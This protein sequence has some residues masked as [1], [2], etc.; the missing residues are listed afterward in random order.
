MGF[1]LFSMARVAEDVKVELK[2]IKSCDEFLSKVLEIYR[3]QV[4]VD[5]RWGAPAFTLVLA[6]GE[7]SV[8]LVIS[9]RLGKIDVWW[10]GQ[11]YEEYVEM[12]VLEE[13]YDYLNERLPK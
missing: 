9:G 5:D 1:R 2:K 8:D 10:G 3:T 4:L 7:P 6:T 11:H 12:D 13:L